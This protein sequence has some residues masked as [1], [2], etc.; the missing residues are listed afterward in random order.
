MPA[1]TANDLAALA[2]REVNHDQAEAIISIVT[3]RAA[4]HT[5]GRGFTA[6]VP[7]DDIWSVILTASLR[8]LADPSG[9]VT[10]QR[11]G[12]FS[13][14]L[15]PFEGWTTSELMTLNRYRERAR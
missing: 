10:E 3:A 5:R 1:P 2:G 12:P 11:M 9:A 8:M 14:S 7:A 4:S 15:K 6:G 13:V